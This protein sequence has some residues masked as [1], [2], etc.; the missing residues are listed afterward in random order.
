MC[1]VL[2]LFVHAVTPRDNYSLGNR[3][4]LTQTIQMELFEKQETLS[5]FFFFFFECL[6]STLNFDR[7][8]KKEHPDS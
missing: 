2:K 5:Q 7:F 6:K 1:K 8:P 3:D 4:N